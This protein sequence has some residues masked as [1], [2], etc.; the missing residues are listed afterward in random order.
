MHPAERVRV[1][2]FDFDAY[3]A[4]IGLSAV[5]R[6]AA[7]LF[8]L[9]AAQLRS[10]PFENLDPFL[11]T[12]PDIALDAVFA[13]TVTEFRGGYCFELNALLGAAL[14]TAGFPVRRALARVRKGAPQGGP[15]S[16]LVLFTEVDG[17]RYLADAGF[18]GP[19]A[20]VPL[21]I[22]RATPQSAPNGHYRLRDDPVSGERVVERETSEGWFAIYGV[23]DAW[24]GDMDLA[25]AN[26]ACATW[27]YFPFRNHL[28]INGYEGNRRIGIFDRTVTEETESRSTRSTIHDFAGF[29]DVVAGQIGV[30]IGHDI[31]AAAWGRLVD[32]DPSG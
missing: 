23:D 22:G 10:V 30:S 12:V 9:Q 15:R 29:E 6:T 3:L 13:K 18:G 1:A 32:P 4:R 27:E 19:G 25:A 5:P 16:H 24:V 21:E 11:G 26:Y 8:A 2:G 17:R 14:A 31:L 7:G 28:M 20:L